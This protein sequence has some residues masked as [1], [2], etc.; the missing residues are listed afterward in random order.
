MKRGGRVVL[1]PGRSPKTEIGEIVHAGVTT[2]KICDYNEL[3]KYIADEL[4]ALAKRRDAWVL[5]IGM[6]GPKIYLRDAKKIV[7]SL[8]GTLIRTETS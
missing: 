4:L 8:D 2:R 5:D 1:I 6:W 7:N 3:V